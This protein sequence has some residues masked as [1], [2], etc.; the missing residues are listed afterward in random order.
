M[1]RA[2]ALIAETRRPL[3]EIACECGFADQAHMTRAL[4]KM[5]GETPRRLR[6]LAT[7]M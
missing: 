4:H 2:A 6:C 3:A 1:R 7:A 5:L